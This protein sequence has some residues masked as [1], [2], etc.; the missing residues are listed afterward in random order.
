MDRSTEAQVSGV[1]NTHA[2]KSMLNFF[3]SSQCAGKSFDIKTMFS[4][5][6]LMVSACQ[7][8]GRGFYKLYPKDRDN[9]SKTKGKTKQNK[10]FN[11]SFLNVYKPIVETIF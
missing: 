5:S 4:Y 2:L 3:D 1:L 6:F 8:A 7:A 10:E 9:K 11:S